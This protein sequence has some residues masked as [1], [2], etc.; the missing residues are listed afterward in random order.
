M[1]LKMQCKIFC[2]TVNINIESGDYIPYS[3]LFF[4]GKVFTNWNHFS[5]TVVFNNYFA[6]TTPYDTELIIAINSS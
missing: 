4:R 2:Y 5:A 3:G 6:L 1:R